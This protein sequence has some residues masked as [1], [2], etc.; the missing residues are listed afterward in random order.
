MCRR[1]TE[2]SISRMKT[3][4][5]TLQHVWCRLHRPLGYFPCF[6]KYRC[7]EFSCICPSYSH[8]PDPWRDP[9]DQPIFIWLAVFWRSL[10]VCCAWGRV[11]QGVE[12]GI[13]TEQVISLGCRAL[14][15]GG[16]PL[17]AAAESLNRRL[18]GDNSCSAPLS[19]YYMRQCLY[20]Q[21]QDQSLAH[22]LAM[23]PGGSVLLWLIQ[24]TF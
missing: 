20:C 11:P 21:E 7:C 14:Q 2:Y 19:I 23:V 8:T 5:K 6:P 16:S 9:D 18:C 10:V 12:S 3:A 4:F 1:W 13:G 15:Q 17:E 24:S 22:G